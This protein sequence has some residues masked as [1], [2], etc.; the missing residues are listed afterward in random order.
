MTKLSDFTV[1]ALFRTDCYSGIKSN[2]AVSY[3]EPLH[4]CSCRH[5]EKCAVPHEVAASEG[6]L[7][8]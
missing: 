3:I 2:Y 6:F 7:L 5:H 1:K 8:C 4:L